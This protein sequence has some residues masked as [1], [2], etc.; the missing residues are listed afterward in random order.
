MNNLFKEFN[1][2]SAAAWKQQIQVDLKGADYN[3]TLLTPTNEGIT[4]KPFYHKDDF[5][6]IQVPKTL[7]DFKICQVIL[8]NDEESHQIVKND[9]NK[10]VDAF[11]FI[12]NSTFDYELLLSQVKA[13]NIEI[14]F[15][16]NFFSAEFLSSLIEYLKDEDVYYNIDIIGKLV[17]SGNWYQNQKNDFN[18]LKDLLN[19]YPTQKLISINAD[20]YQNAGANTVQQLAYALAHANEYFTYFGGEIVKYMQFNF[21]IGNNYFF[22]IAKLRTFRY[23]LQLILKEYAI[24]SD[25][26]IYAEPSSRNKT[27]YDYNLNMLRTTTECMSAVLGGANT[28]SNLPYDS[29]FHNYNDFGNR[30]ARNQLLIIKEEAG[31]KNAQSI[32]NDSYYI[33][34]LSKQMAEKALALFKEIEASG[35]FINQLFNG[36]IQRKIDENAAKE[37]TQF[38]AGELVLLGTNKYPNDLDKMKG[39]LQKDPFQKSNPIKTL[40]PPIISKR[41]AQKLEL[42]RLENEA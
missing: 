31:F 17:K 11:K 19:K 40:I 36:T 1:I 15:H 8:I 12:A 39:E 16:F 21:A 24:K 33:E 22:E 23:L 20:I 10:G 5:K 32:P 14:H 25:I 6:K 28:I 18:L 2:V 35:G 38:D 26:H 3:Q 37:Q 13:K 9:I 41:L 34:E 4:I 30:I 29:L 42:K 27:L 7:G